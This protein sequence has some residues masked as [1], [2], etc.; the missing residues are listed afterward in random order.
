MCVFR[1][2]L[3][4]QISKHEKKIEKK[5]LVTIKNLYLF[6]FFKSITMF[7]EW[8]YIHTTSCLIVFS[9]P[10]FLQLYGYYIGS[11]SLH[12]KHNLN[13]KALN[14]AIL[15]KEVFLAYQNVLIY[16]FNLL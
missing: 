14:E 5:N 6:L 12:G 13:L 15:F 9:T 2:F 7:D 1:I 3:K 10:Y 4:F 16:L 11:K 8:S